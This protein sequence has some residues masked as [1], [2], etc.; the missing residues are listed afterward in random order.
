MENKT[1]D[2]LDAVD[3]V[4]IECHYLNEETCATCPVR[5]TVEEKECLSK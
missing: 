3:I 5:K 1:M 4:C 2:F